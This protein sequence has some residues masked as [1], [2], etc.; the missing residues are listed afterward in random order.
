MFDKNK[1]TLQILFTVYVTHS[2]WR[3]TQQLNKNSIR[4]TRPCCCLVWT[5]YLLF[6]LGPAYCN[7]SQNRI[8]L[9]MATL[10]WQ[11]AT[12]LQGHNTFKSFLHLSLFK[13]KS[14]YLIYRNS[15]FSSFYVYYTLF[16]HSSIQ[17]KKF[18]YIF[19]TPSEHSSILWPIF[20]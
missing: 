20:H 10:L 9:L 14:S 15:Y 5:K 1:Q 13:F 18:L 8:S 17:S 11:S 12:I 16:Y 6:S 7:V 2:L 19:L 4:N 3:L